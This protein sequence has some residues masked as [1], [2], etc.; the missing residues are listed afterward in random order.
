MLKHGQ[1]WVHVFV[2]RRSAAPYKYS[3]ARALETLGTRCF[4]C[5]GFDHDDVR[6]C[7]NVRVS[8]AEYGATD[9]R[10]GRYRDTPTE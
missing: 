7:Q 4:R 3:R 2:L 9:Y 5:G 1:D 8:D 10:P 6:A